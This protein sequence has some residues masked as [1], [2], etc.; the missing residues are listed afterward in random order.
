[1]TNP[2]IPMPAENPDEVYIQ[3][4]VDRRAA[5][6]QAEGVV[7]TFE[8]RPRSEDW[9]AAGDISRNAQG[10]VISRL[11]LRAK[12]PA[13][14]GVT[15]GLLRRIQVSDILHVARAHVALAVQAEVEP[16]VY[17]PSTS[18]QPRSGGRGALSAELLRSVAVA[19]LAETAPGRPAGAVKR[20]AAEFE[21]PEETVRSWISRA[22]KAGWLGPSVKGR[23]GAEPGPRLRDLTQEEFGRIFPEGY[24][25]P[26]QNV[27]ELAAGF[28]SMS[29]ERQRAASHAWFTPERQAEYNRA[30]LEW[31]RKEQERP[32]EGRPQDGTADDADDQQGGQ[33]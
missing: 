18:S 30:A 11:E 9:E 12:D 6:E 1:M 23:A 19:Y 32:A 31:E 16:V 13:G 3:A 10:L 14:N 25:E 33:G 24:D 26:P 29:K 8:C 17:P 5:A 21:R 27:T 15:G 7:A 2:D 28:S 4:H 22:R 20:M